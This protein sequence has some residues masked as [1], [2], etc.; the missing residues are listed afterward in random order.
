MFSRPALSEVIDDE[1]YTDYGIGLIPYA[2]PGVLLFLAT[3]IAS[4]VWCCCA[5]KKRRF[6]TIEEDKQVQFNNRWM[7]IVLY[8]VLLLAS[9][10]T[11]IVFVVLAT[12][13]LTGLISD[14]QQVVDAV[15]DRADSVNATITGIK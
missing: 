12:N 7:R 2:V 10:I 6:S 14:A 4:I 15:I 1:E 3:L 8:D 5:C 11:S 13:G 9:V